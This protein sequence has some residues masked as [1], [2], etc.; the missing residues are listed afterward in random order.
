MTHNGIPNLQKDGIN[1]EVDVQEIFEPL[2]GEGYYTFDS[3]SEDEGVSSHKTSKNI[4]QATKLTRISKSNDYREQTVQTNSKELQGGCPI[5]QNKNN[6][7]S[8]CCCPRSSR[9]HMRDKSPYGYPKVYVLP[10]HRY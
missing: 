6:I 5:H 4:E 9:V 10:R 3:E 1:F 7:L 2:L 8:G